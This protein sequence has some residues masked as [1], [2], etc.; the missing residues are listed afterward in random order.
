MGFGCTVP[1]LMQQYNEAAVAVCHHVDNPLMS[2]SAILPSMFN[3]LEHFSLKSQI[4]DVIH[5]FH[6]NCIS[7]HWH[8]YQT[9]L[10]SE[11][12]VPFVNGT[13]PESLRPVR[14]SSNTCGKK[15]VNIS[16]KWGEIF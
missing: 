9:I 8:V 4:D 14:R 11:E 13:S 15:P 16:T 10:F 2:C 12:D 3:L 5:L 6:W 1:A 7:S